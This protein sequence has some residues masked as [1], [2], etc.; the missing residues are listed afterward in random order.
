MPKI[1]KFKCSDVEDDSEDLEVSNEESIHIGE[2][3]KEI[4]Q[5][6]QPF[7]APKTAKIIEIKSSFRLHK[8]DSEN[9]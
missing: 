1:E 9:E 6:Q 7:F 4:M 8:E 5:I 3:D 2:Q